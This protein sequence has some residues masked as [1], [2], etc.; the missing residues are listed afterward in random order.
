MC[1]NPFIVMLVYLFAYSFVGYFISNVE[2][3]VIAMN[4]NN[5]PSKNTIIRYR[6][7]KYKHTLKDQQPKENKINRLMKQR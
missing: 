4:M 6:K 7:V 1:S 3:S 5:I 2:N